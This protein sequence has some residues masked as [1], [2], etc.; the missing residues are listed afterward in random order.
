MQYNEQQIF[1]HKLSAEIVDGIIGRAFALVKKRKR[2]I[3]EKT[4]FNFIKS[5]FRK[6]DLLFDRQ[7][8]IVAFNENAAFPHYRLTGNKRLKENTLI[9]VDAWARLGNRNAPYAD[10]TRIAYFGKKVP[11][12]ISANF[13][14]IL[15]ARDSAIGFIR[16]NL[17][18]GRLP[19]A[20][21]VDN[22]A[23]S[24]I[25]NAGYGENFIHST[26][27]TLGIRT[28]HG[29]ERLGRKARQ[30]VRMNMLYAVEPGIYFRGKYGMRSEV[31]ILVRKKEIIVTTF[32]PKK[33][34]LIKP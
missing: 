20:K 12:D 8:C 24:I 9:L 5:E 33:I 15:R 1:Q 34:L 31:D 28:V 4:I 14:L 18:K 2:S 3:D 22:A 19:Y 30:K 26:G 21:D 16:K 13:S 27:H 6:N 10:I 23:R 32:L 29:G 17:A 11:K 7:A 25:S